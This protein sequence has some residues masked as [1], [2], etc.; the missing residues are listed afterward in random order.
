VFDPSVTSVRLEQ[1]FAD[2]FRAQFN[3]TLIGG[4]EEPF[5][6]AGGSEPARI[7]YR[8]DY[9]A[10]A[11]HEVAHWCLAGER[12]RQVDDYGYWYLVEGRDLQQ[13]SLFEE[14]ELRPQALELLFTAACGGRF[15]VSVDNLELSGYDS[16]GFSRRVYREAIGWLEAG[17]PERAALFAG[18]LCDTFTQ[19]PLTVEA[20]KRACLERT[21][22]AGF[23]QG[24]TSSGRS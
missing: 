8:A 7:F 2:C 3:T 12:R 10:S 22:W 9:V 14:A 16:T 1:L 24:L 15:Q 11:L 6:E 5:Y 13:Q 18:A 21:F 20:V 19:S 23:S 17:L 4:A